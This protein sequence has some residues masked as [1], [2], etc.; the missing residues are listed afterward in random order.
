MDFDTS[1]FIRNWNGRRVADPLLLYVGMRED[2]IYQCVS[3]AKQYMSE[4]F[5]I[6]NGYYGN[7]IDWWNNTPPSFYPF[8]D[9]IATQDV[10]EGDVVILFGLKGNTDGHIGVGSGKENTSQFELSEQNGSTGN[11]S[12][13][14]G[15]AIRT[16]WID[17]SRIAGVLRPKPVVASP[18]PKPYYIVTPPDFVPKE[19]IAKRET[20]KFDLAHQTEADMLGHIIEKQAPGLRITATALLHHNA[21]TKDYYLQ[22]KDNPVGYWVG[23]FDDYVVP[24]PPAPYKAPEVLYNIQDK[25]AEKYTLLTD[26]LC[27]PTSGNAASQTTPNGELAKGVYYVH[28]RD[29]DMINLSLGNMDRDVKQWINPRKNV[30]AVEEPKPVVVPAPVAVPEKIIEAIT[31]AAEKIPPAPVTPAVPA[32]PTPE[33]EWQ[34]IANELSQHLSLFNLDGSAVH[35]N[36]NN[37]RPLFVEDMTGAIDSRTNKVAVTRINPFT[38]HIPMVG[39]I[40]IIED[41]GRKIRYVLPAACYGTSKWYLA[42]MSSFNLDKKTVLDKAVDVVEGIYNDIRTSDHL[43]A[44]QERIKLSIQGF[45]NK[46]KKD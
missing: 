45:V 37:S 26:L 25:M 35:Y 19:V 10:Q 18:P 23:D 39:T 30:V 46:M 36:S 16:R 22:D 12:G 44:A 2:Q 20:I 3:Y 1:A 9:R 34:Q 29:R 24:A 11:G 14:N 13:L 8:I 7:A 33:Q 5:H 6:P 32:G 27:F 40:D 4:R 17:K 31:V 42:P 43:T 38:K 15:D 41:D 21:T 28:G